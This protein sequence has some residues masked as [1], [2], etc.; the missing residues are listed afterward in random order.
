MKVATEADVE[1][2]EGAKVFLPRSLDPALGPRPHMAASAFLGGAAAAPPA[3][4]LRL[5]TA[6]RGPLSGLRLAMAPRSRP[7][8]QGCSPNRGDGPRR[9]VCRNLWQEGTGV[10]ARLR[11]FSFT[12]IPSVQSRPRRSCRR[13]KAQCTLAAIQVVDG[14]PPVLDR[15][16]P[17]IVTNGMRQAN[18]QPCR[19]NAPE[20][21]EHKSSPQT[22]PEN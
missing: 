17:R 15:A 7:S 14:S 19:F 13:G 21:C 8:P 12:D 11:F 18:S 5:A 22:C 6:H 20:A 2:E 16:A 10:P 1:R 9:V 4:G 3:P